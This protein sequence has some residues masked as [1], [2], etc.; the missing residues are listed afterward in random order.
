M[1]R[2]ENETSQALLGCDRR[3]VIRVE[4]VR[5]RARLTYRI[6]LAFWLTPQIRI[7]QPKRRPKRSE[8]EFHVVIRYGTETAVPRFASASAV[9]AP[10][11]SVIHCCV[12]PLEISHELE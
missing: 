5:I 6:D 10:R 3:N 12:R 8:A 7:D 2:E 11:N 4:H 9:S 1:A